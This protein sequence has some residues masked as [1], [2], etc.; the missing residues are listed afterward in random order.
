MSRIKIFL[1]HR[2]RW[3]CII[4]SA[5]NHAFSKIEIG[6]SYNK[7]YK[8]HNF[9][10]YV[11]GGID[12][13]KVGN[14]KMYLPDLIFCIKSLFSFTSWLF[15]SEVVVLTF[16][17]NYLDLANLFARSKNIVSTLPQIFNIRCKM[18]SKINT[19]V[20]RDMCTNIWSYDGIPT[21][22]QWTNQPQQWWG[23]QKVQ[24]F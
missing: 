7:K 10:F 3:T 23:S 20:K 18:L 17:K 19:K 16:P 2:S 1:S 21:I 8:M 13:V 5:M 11:M 24:F 22:Y 9:W 6:S 14:G 15:L 4:K 12:H